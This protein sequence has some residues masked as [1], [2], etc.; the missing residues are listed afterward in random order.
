MKRILCF[1]LAFVA[2]TF[3]ACN[4]NTPESGK[5]PQSAYLIDN[6][7]IDEVCV[8]LEKNG[9]QNT[10]VY[11]EWV[12]D[13]SDTSAKKTELPQQWTKLSD[14]K[15]DTFACADY[16]EKTHNYSDANCR[17][18]AML[19]MGD[20][21]KVDNPEK[22]YNGTYIMMDVDAI[23]NEAKYSMIKDRYYEF[24]TLFGETAISDI[25][26]VNALPQNWEKHG[27]HFDAENISLISVVME[28][29]MSPTAFV[30]HTGLLIDEGDHLLFVE[31][32]AF[33][34]PYQATKFNN[35]NE[36]VDM[37]SS[38]PEYA[39]EDGKAPSVI[40]CNNEVIGQ[41]KMNN[42]E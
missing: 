39:A 15:G 34:Q 21:I 24:T 12:K 4:K 3:T 33:E 37:L 31:K 10:S 27:I 29:T 18:T 42:K 41:V 11:K 32:L 40:C 22:E 5:L 38:R 16:W 13:F 20:L 17:M 23:E 6:K 7:I 25:G 28:D 26:L 1:I 36:L 2:V 19:L 30:G 35:I 8:A 14:L 9:L